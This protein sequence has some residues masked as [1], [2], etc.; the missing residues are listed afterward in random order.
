MVPRAPRARSWMLLAA[1]ALAAAGC[2][3]GPA[4]DMQRALEREDYAEVI[5]LGRHALKT[6]PVPARVHLYYG[7][8]LVARG[9]D[10][11]GLP[12]LEAAVGADSSLARDAAV[13]LW[14]RTDGTRADAA[15]R[16]RRAVELSPDIKPGARRFAIAGDYFENRLWQQAANEYAAAVEEYPDT[17]ACELALSRLAECW[18]ALGDPE[19]SRA[20][21]AA[22]VKRYP[23]GSLARGAASDLVGIKFEEAQA[24]YQAGDYPLAIELSRDV[25]ERAANRLLQQRARLLLGE[26]YEA[27]GDRNAAYEAYQEIVRS[28]RGDSGRLVEQAR[29]RIVALQ[30]GG[31]E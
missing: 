31:Q 19:R 25:V 6:E 17:S 8:A 10:Q 29:A 1:L 5:T 23:R 4:A 11:E 24:A 20:A 26:A 16:W 15:H 28:D 21:M 22:L 27:S 13:F 12:A 30:E 7:M 18:T 3:R 9:R 2:G 14:G